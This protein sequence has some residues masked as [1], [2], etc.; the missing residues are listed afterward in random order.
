MRH[1]TSFVTT[2]SFHG[3]TALASS[4]AIRFASGKLCC[5][6]HGLRDHSPTGP[7]CPNISFLVALGIRH[8]R[9]WVT[10]VLSWLLSCTVGLANDPRSDARLLELTVDGEKLQGRQLISNDETCWLLQRDGQ[11]LSVD[12]RYV[13]AFRKVAD[14]YRPYSA[15]EMRSRLLDE[16]GKSYEF[17]VRGNHFVLSPP[18]KARVCA[19]IVEGTSRSFISYFSRRNLKLDKFESPMTTVVFAEHN[20]FLEYCKRD[21]VAATKGLRGYYSPSKNRVALYLESKGAAAVRREMPSW[22]DLEPATVPFSVA[23]AAPQAWRLTPLAAPSGD[24]F[25]DTLVHETTHQLGF[26]SGVHSRLGDDPTWVVEGLA[27]LF[28]GDANRDDTR[29]RTTVGQRMNRERYLWF[30]EYA[31]A[32]RRPKS[33]EAFLTTNALFQTNTLDAYSEAWALMFF[34]A[35]TRGSQLPKYLRLLATRTEVGE[36]EPSRRLHDFQTSFSKDIARLEMEYLRYMQELESSLPRP[37]VTVAD[38]LTGP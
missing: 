20:K 25:R 33:L 3:V 14:V 31:K 13:T 6:R 22:P 29:Q 7:A 15:K 17:D 26:N 24:D 16:F 8:R 18:G 38:P 34:L 12:L 35:E 28:E 21:N 11:L 32:R 9:L 4:Q 37:A 27:M 23:H 36:Y 19:D 2:G 10:M 30:M 5:P 1:R